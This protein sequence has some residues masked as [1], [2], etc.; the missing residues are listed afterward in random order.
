MAREMG[1]SGRSF[2]RKFI[3]STGGTPARWLA[4]V[5]IDEAKRLLETTRHPI[6]RVADLIGFGSVQVLR[7]HFRKSV[8]ITPSE[9]RDRFAARALEM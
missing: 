8:G 2:Q 9:Y 1:M 3:Q 4:Q 5:R 6:E 7:V